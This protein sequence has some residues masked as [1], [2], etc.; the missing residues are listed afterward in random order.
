MPSTGE[1]KLEQQRARRKQKAAAKAA[2][3]E[4]SKKQSLGVSVMAADLDAATSANPQEQYAAKRN[5]AKREKRQRA[6]DDSSAASIERLNGVS[7]DEHE[8]F[9]EWCAE[10]GV[11]PSAENL[12]GWRATAEY[13][14][15]CLDELGDQEYADFS[16]W[17]Q[18]SGLEENYEALCDWRSSHAY[19]QVKLR[20]LRPRRASDD[21]S[22]SDRR[23]TCL[24]GV[25]RW[26]ASHGGLVRGH[27]HVRGSMELARSAQLT[28]EA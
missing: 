22:L 15:F 5:A 3:S 13:E 14:E 10:L 9:A 7:H 12:D 11:E 6:Q 2:A 25:L 28:I 19:E 27:A 16:S 24:A 1:A 4:C 21:P 8:A 18:R 23:G 26:S 17:L 20:F